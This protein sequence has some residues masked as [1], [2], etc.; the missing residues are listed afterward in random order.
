MGTSGKRSFKTVR[1]RTENDN[2]KL[3]GDQILLVFDPLVDSEQDLESG[4]FRCHEKVP[5]LEP[6]EA[7]VTRSLAVVPMQS[8]PES[9][10]HAFVDQNAHLGA[11]EQEFFRFF[12]S[13]DGGFA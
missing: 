1:L 7:S 9:L 5:I 2:C 8:V 6:G 3:S 13:S 11:R 4:F 10:I 12:E